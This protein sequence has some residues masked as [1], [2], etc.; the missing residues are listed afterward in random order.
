[1]IKLHAIALILNGDGLMPLRG[2]GV[3]EKKAGNLP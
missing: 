3:I 1:M 2:I